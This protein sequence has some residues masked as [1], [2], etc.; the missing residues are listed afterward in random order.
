MVFSLFGTS[1]R[2]TQEHTVP[3][4]LADRAEA[5]RLL[6]ERLLSFRNQPDWIVIA[7][8]RGG[9]VVGYQ[10]ASALHLPLD[11]CIVRKLGCPSEPELAIGAIGSG[12]VQ[13]LNPDVLRRME[14]KP[15]QIEAEIASERRELQRREA[16]YRSGRTANPV[17][18]KTVILVDDGV[19]TGATLSAAIRVLKAQGAKRLVLALGAGSQYALQQLAPE[20]DET[21]CLLIP[22]PFGAIGAWYRDFRQTS[23]AEVRNLLDRAAELVR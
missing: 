19:A 16:L 22:E 2:K 8:P 13:I 23:D 18:G 15:Q 20:V 11:V 7:L 21:V 17:D 12:G 1:G 6:A 10:I 4:V 14:I 5:G 9:V 3:S